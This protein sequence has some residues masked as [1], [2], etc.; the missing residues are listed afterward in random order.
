MT[1]E[2]LYYDPLLASFYDL[3]NR[4][5]PDFDFCARLARHAQSVLDLGCGTGELAVHLAKGRH[6]IGV[7]PAAA[8]L[9]V[10]RARPGGDRVTWIE[11]DART[12]D[13]GHRFDLIV[14]TGH[15]FQVFL[16]DTEQRKVLSAIARHLTPEGRFVFDMRNAAVRAWEDWTPEKTRREVCHPEFG[17]VTTETRASYDPEARIVAY[18]HVFH[19][20]LG[21]KAVTSRIRFDDRAH[22]A[23]LLEEA[24]LQAETWHGDWD[25]RPWTP[26]SREIIPVGRLAR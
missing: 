1:G 22:I 4:W 3:E 16:T 14:L 9:D 15:A 6:V 20:P 13:L 19:L 10:A 7:D 17:P 21:P 25:G 18:T 2:A 26:A 8:M 23:R 11:A 5:A 12:L 24:G